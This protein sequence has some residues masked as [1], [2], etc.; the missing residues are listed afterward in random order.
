MPVPFVAMTCLSSIATV[1][2]C[3]DR[4][5]NSSFLLSSE[6]KKSCQFRGTVTDGRT[7]LLAPVPRF[8]L[9]LAFKLFGIYSSKTRSSLCT[10]SSDCTM[11]GRKT[12]SLYS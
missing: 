2:A 5:E 12:L 4:N 10:F 3:S 9:V 11:Y 6:R 1:T 8:S 7:F